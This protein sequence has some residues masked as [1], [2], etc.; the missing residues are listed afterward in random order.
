VSLPFRV[1]TLLEPNP[2]CPPST[3]EPPAEAGFP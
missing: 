3:G 1:G 2:E